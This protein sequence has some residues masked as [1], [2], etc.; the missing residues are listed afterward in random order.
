MFISCRYTNKYSEFRI[1][2]VLE[3]QC[4]KCQIATASSPY[5]TFDQKEQIPQD[6]YENRFYV[7]PSNQS[8]FLILLDPHS[9]TFSIHIINATVNGF[10]SS[11]SWLASWIFTSSHK[12]DILSCHS[13]RTYQ[14]GNILSFNSGMTYL[15][16]ETNCMK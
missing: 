2:D 10:N 6:N 1:N 11:S 7:D 3:Y 12:T 15:K 16:N 5:F 13:P 9:S 14:V 4:F 8:L